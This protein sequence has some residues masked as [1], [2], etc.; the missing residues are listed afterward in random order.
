MEELK[1][2][3]CPMCRKKEMALME[4][5]KEIAHFGKCFIMSMTCGNCG[6]KKEKKDEKK[7]K[8]EKKEKKKKKS[9]S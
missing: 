8:K 6:N 9:K 1:N 7:A 4:D 3:E 2:Q 5:V